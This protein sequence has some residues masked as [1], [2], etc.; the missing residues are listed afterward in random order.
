MADSPASPGR[1]PI[2]GQRWL[3]IAVLTV[4]A[5][6]VS[7]L[8]ITPRVVFWKDYPDMV[9]ETARLPSLVAQLADP[10]H[11]DQAYL[12]NPLFGD[13]ALRWRLLPPVVGHA[14]HLPPKVYLGL[15]WLGLFFLVGASLHYLQ[16]RGMAPLALLAT[17]VLI[18]TSAV[19]FGSSTSIGYFDC[20]YLLGLVIFCFTPSPLV[21]VIACLLGPWCDEKFLLLLPACALLRW[22]WQPGWNWVAGAALGVALYCGARLTALAGGDSSLS[23]QL[24]MQGKVF[25]HYW[26]SLPLGWWHGFRAGWIVIGVGTWLAWRQLP[27]PIGL[28]FL[29]GLLAALG[30]ISFLAWDTTRSIA[31][32]FPLFLVGAAE[33]RL[34]RGLVWM[35]VL[36]VLLPAAYLCCADPVRVPLTSVLH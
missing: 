2:D 25:S 12:N 36:N 33:P 8:A 21:A 1:V 35:A 10:I 22:S 13:N 6:G 19:F 16:R 24:A 4:A 3:L 28:V 30:A 5:M 11:W 9:F 18:G 32:L 34:Q 26:R 20:L 27:R 14:L 31:M 17:G 29:A 7:V 23:L 15:P